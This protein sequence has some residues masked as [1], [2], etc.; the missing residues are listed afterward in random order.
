MRENT[1]RM[2]S[3]P[4][5]AARETCPICGGPSSL[6]HRGLY[7]DRYGHPG[8]Y[9][10][11]VCGRD[12]H[13]FV[14]TPFDAAELA[15]LYSDWYPRA[16]RRYEDLPP[17]AGTTGFW[18]WLNGERHA[19]HS[20]VPPDVAVLDIGCGFGRTL[21]FHAARGC[22]AV[23]VEADE[24]GVAEARRQGLEVEHGLFDPA[25]YEAGS[26][27]YVT[28]D[29]VLEHAQDPVAFMA[30]VATVLKPGGVVVISTPN[31]GGYAARLFGVR[32]I[33]WHTPY[34]LNL[35]TR[36][37]LRRLAEETGFSVRSIRTI[38]SSSWLRYQWYHWFTRPPAG[39]PSRF[40]DPKRSTGRIRRRVRTGAD[41]LENIK[42]LQLAT[43][44]AD[45]L[46]VGDNMLA[47]LVKEPRQ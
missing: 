9:D 17:L 35:F 21:A 46:G 23:G 42:A 34:H 31:A 5:P 38:T 25:R 36:R 16:A 39:E 29:Q 8:A 18:A 44:L 11:R 30:G 47:I 10:V 14:T 33:N 22:R 4:P 32:W 45:G 37:S 28:M 43:R 6:R 12:G 2:T 41:I 24:H 7:D 40:W 27:D 13:A 1:Q 20:W 26:F 15:T 3:L 19:A